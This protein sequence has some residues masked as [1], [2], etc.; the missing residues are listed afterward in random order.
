MKYGKDGEFQDP[1]VRCD[2]CQAINT[3]EEIQKF[4]SCKQCDSRRVRNVL[5]LTK[6]EY[7]YLEGLHIDEDF[8]SLF[9]EVA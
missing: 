1:I 6:E 9:E 7:A 4:G 5:T 8:L 2:S 3:R